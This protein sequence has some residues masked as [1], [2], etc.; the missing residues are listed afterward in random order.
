LS[1]ALSNALS[2]IHVKTLSKASSYLDIAEHPSLASLQLAETGCLWM[3]S[4]LLLVVRARSLHL[5]T[6]PDWPVS[7]V[8]RSFCAPGQCPAGEDCPCTGQAGGSSAIQFF[9]GCGML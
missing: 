6:I 8:N 3:A 7:Q 2:E 1:D 9:S 4:F 5:E